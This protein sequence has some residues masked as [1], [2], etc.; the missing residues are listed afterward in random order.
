[1]NWIVKCATMHV[2]FLYSEL[3]IR[4]SLSKGV[5]RVQTRQRWFKCKMR[6]NRKLL[7][8]ENK[9]RT[10]VK[11]KWCVCVCECFLYEI[12][13]CVCVWE[14]FS[15]YSVTNISILWFEQIETI[16]VSGVT[17]TYTMISIFMKEKNQKV[18]INEGDLM[19]NLFFLQIKA[20]LFK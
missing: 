15:L 5:F 4:V 8:M 11:L 6:L 3:R 20:D 1:M 18:H 7:P 2:F 9:F 13:V 12:F 14:L 19:P 17:S 16:V 10:S